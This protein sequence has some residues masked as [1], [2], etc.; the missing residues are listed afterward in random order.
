M[1]AGGLLRRNGRYRSASG[2][3]WQY[4]AEEAD[5]ICCPVRDQCLSEHDRRGA[6]KPEDSYFN[7]SVQ[8]SRSRQ[9]TNESW[10]VLEKRQVWCEGTF[11]TQKWGHNLTRVLRRGLEAAEDHGLLSAAAL[12]LF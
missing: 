6:R 2:L 10:Q 8:R 9:N 7:P 4:Q 11:A 1:S 3:F 12:N 5:G